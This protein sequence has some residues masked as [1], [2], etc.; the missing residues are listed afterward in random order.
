[1]NIQNLMKQA[2]QMQKDLAAN[3]QK[4]EAQQFVGKS[5][6]VE[7]EMSG[8][9][10]LQN[11]KITNDLG[12]DPEDLEMLEDA[13]MLAINNTMEDIDKESEKIMGNM[14]NMPGLF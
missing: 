5:S 3:Q 6:L 10:K 14:P 2:K 11:V 4:L 1:M 13:I 7:I 9:K 12:L 8:T